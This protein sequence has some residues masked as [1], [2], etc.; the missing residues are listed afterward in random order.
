MVSPTQLCWR[1]HSLPP[2]QWYILQSDVVTLC[3][4]GLSKYRLRIT[5]NTMDSGLFAMHCRLM[6]LVGIRPTISQRPLT[7]LKTQLDSD[8]GSL[9]SAPTLQV[10]IH[11][12][13]LFDNYTSHHK[14]WSHCNTLHQQCIVKYKLECIYLTLSSNTLDIKL[15]CTYNVTHEQSRNNTCMHLPHS[16]MKWKLPH[17]PQ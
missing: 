14:I 11:L 7:A 12:V 10:A 1:Y 2:S 8:S 6:W 17:G 4:I 13:Q 15:F 5:T 3:M 16:H 9:V